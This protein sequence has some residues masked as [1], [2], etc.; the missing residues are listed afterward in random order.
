LLAQHFGIDNLQRDN[1]A[2]IDIERFVSDPHAATA[3]LN[4][5][6]IRIQQNPIM[7]ETVL[8]L[9]ATGA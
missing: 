1:T 6:T 4:P 5:C 3:K 8:R 7:L 2:Q 9:A